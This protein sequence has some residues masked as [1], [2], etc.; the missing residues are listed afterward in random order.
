MNRIFSV[1]LVTVL[2]CVSTAAM[3]QEPSARE[4][5][6]EELVRKL[7]DKV[8]RLE[9]RLGQVEETKAAGDTEARVEQL[10]QSVRKIKDERPPAAD[11][12]EWTKIRKWVND[13]S[14]LWPHWKDGLRF[15]SNDGSVKLKIGGRIQNDYA[16]FAEDGDLE[17]R[18]GED[19]DDGTEFRRA[20][21]Y[22]SGTI[23]DDID[24]KMQYDFAGGDADFKDVYLGMKNVPYV[25]HVRVGQF[26]EPFSLEELASSNNITFMERSLVN[27][28]APS[29]NT[30][31]MIYD[32]MKDRRMT[33]AAGL[34]RQTDD[35][36]NGSGGRALNATARLTGLPWYKDKGR[37]LLHLGVA[38]THQ[39][40]EDDT[41]RFR[42]LREAHLAPRLGDTGRFSAEY[43]DFIGAE[44]AL[45][46]GPFSLEGEYVHA[47]IEGRSRRIGDPR[48][49]AASIQASYFLTG[50]HR[51]Y[52][53]SAGTFG[54]V[55]PLR[56]YGTDGGPGAWEVGARYS[57]LTLNDGIVRG[58]RVRDL[59][60]GLNW[61]LN[62]NVRM[63]WNY[64]L[65]DPARGGD[66]S[67]F[68]W[69]IQVAF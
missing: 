57:Y 64:V 65:A 51:P 33:W 7:A 52:K 58:G 44:A 32:T 39:N 63:M 68:L 48:F 8:D 66:V 13:S 12:E 30:G 54:R 55:R 2:G 27:T 43:G 19:F 17:R 42:A 38:Y 21:L 47:F 9:S 26:K 61:Y 24:F 45:V 36:G 6:L 50:E 28:F 34:F 41:V 23:Y 22:F 4:R 46:N 25:G 59:T 18:L 1:V 31:V 3:A 10:E 20:R 67:A 16:Y 40:Y 29:R 60:V 15:D 53:T 49:W 62:P 14:T 35:F 5:E 37:K 11:A 69:R 56:N